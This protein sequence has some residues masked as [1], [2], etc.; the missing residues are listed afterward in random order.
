MQFVLRP[1]NGVKAESILAD[2]VDL[3]ALM[4]YI[5]DVKEVRIRVEHDGPLMLIGL[6][7]GNKRKR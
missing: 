4:N 5:K 6:E 3:R 2:F 7:D 1:L